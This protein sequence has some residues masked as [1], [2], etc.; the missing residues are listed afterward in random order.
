METQDEVDVAR[1]SSQLQN[2]DSNR[3]LLELR[4]ILEMESATADTFNSRVAFFFLVGPVAWLVMWLVLDWRW[5]TSLLIA[6]LAAMIIFGSIMGA[7][8]YFTAKSLKRIIIVRYPRNS[9]LF[10]LAVALI[11]ELAASGTSKS[12]MQALRKELAV[13]PVT[14][15]PVTPS[16]RVDSLGR[17]EGDVVANVLAT[18]AVAH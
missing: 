7:R 17:A 13:T 14:V 4:R 5:W 18:S 12:L 10:P 3:N 9:P 11:D 16:R 1:T 15:T 2:S 6:N 8:E